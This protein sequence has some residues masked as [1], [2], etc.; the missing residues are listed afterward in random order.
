MLI[1]L[2]VEMRGFRVFCII[3]A[4]LL[5][6]SL[7]ACAPAPASDPGIAVVSATASTTAPPAPPA[8]VPTTAPTVEATIM[9]EPPPK[10]FEDFD[11]K[12]FEKSTQIDNKWF[13]LKPGTEYVYDGGT[14]ENGEK[15]PHRIV[16]TV[17][18][19]TKVI[20]G[21]RSVATWDRDFSSGDLV[22][23][24]LAFFAQDK[25]GVVWRM[26]EYPE[27]YE[28]G[29][30]SKAPSWLHGYEDAH[31]G[32]AM[33]ANPQAGT[34]SY[35]EGWGPAVD[36]TDRGIVDQLGKETCVPV[37]CY[38]NVLVIAESSKTEVGASQLKY[39]A[40]GVGN[41][42]TDWTGSDKTQEVLVLGRLS[43]LDSVGL[44]E[45]RA[46][47]LEL[48][49][50]AY[51]VNNMYAQTSPL[52]YPEGTPAIIVPTAGP[53]QVGLPAGPSDEILVYAS[54]LTGKTMSGLSFMNDPGPPGGKLIGLPNEGDVL[55]PP[56]ENEPNITFKVQV[57][58]AIPYRCWIHMKVG[59]AKGNSQANVI[60]VQLSGAV[61]Q[62]GKQFLQPGSHSYLTALGPQKPGWAWVECNLSGN[63]SLV[64]FQPG[65]EITVRL[66][67]GMEGVGFDQ[68]VLSATD[69]LKAAPTEVVIE[70]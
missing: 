45:V 3:S 57:L 23:A 21:V 48:E 54:D 64:T 53:S 30:F 62:A 7:P 5:M 12:N 28:N 40:P 58:S 11:P 14:I 15:V 18:D 39:Y 4:L 17:T 49:K 38:K 52:E 47:A 34:P 66:Q 70:K 60:W 31:A 43:H 61:D 8:L 41:V 69:F 25:N 67:A 2:E 26:G 1:K 42:Q 55:N 10:D 36:W 37:D 27:E 59:A 35:S 51:Q 16:I 44:A 19:L 46:Q 6:V 65:G 9:P 33:P 22:E 24:E 13:P 50:H 68:F 20:S 63:T 29:K 56:P 32:I